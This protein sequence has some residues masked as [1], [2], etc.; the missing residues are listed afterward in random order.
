MRRQCS[1]LSFNSV[2][3]FNSCTRPRMLMRCHRSWRMTVLFPSLWCTRL[4]PFPFSLLLSL[5]L[6]LLVWVYQLFVDSVGAP[7]GFRS[8]VAVAQGIGGEWS[9]ASFD[10]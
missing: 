8:L 5:A 10:I 3:A 7:I 9:L 2:T 1:S 6:D 4:T